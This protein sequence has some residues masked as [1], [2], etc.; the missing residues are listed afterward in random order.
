VSADALL[1]V[2]QSRRIQDLEEAIRLYSRPSGK[3]PTPG[4]VR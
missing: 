1:K 4:E 2:Q 3:N